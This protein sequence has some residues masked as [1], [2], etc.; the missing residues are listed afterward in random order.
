MVFADKILDEIE[1]VLHADAHPLARGLVGEPLAVVD[2]R[3]ADLFGIFDWWK[4]EG[5]WAIAR[6]K[7]KGARDREEISDAVKGRAEDEDEEQGVWGRGLNP[8]IERE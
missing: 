4:S 8:R 2:L 1:R 7:R 3:R 6:V 5:R